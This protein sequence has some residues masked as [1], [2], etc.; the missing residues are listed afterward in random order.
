[1]LS[2]CLV[3]VFQ[4]GRS[5]CNMPEGLSPCTSKIPYQVWRGE[6]WIIFLRWVLLLLLFRSRR[7]LLVVPPDG[8]IG[9]RLWTSGPVSL[10]LLFRSRR[11]GKS[12][13][14]DRALRSLSFS[15]GHHGGGGPTLN[16]TLRLEPLDTNAPDLQQNT[17]L[18]HA[19]AS[20]FHQFGYDPRDYIQL[21]EFR[22]PPCD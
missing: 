21:H 17:R 13:P 8:H 22:A 20:D 15:Y 7:V 10:L 18:H 2:P 5:F 16:G 19:L 1:M 11:V 4:S 14:P 12:S 9:C 3:P 6:T